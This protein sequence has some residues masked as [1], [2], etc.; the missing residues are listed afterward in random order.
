MDLVIG[1]Y[2]GAGREAGVLP[3]AVRCRDGGQ[4]KCMGRSRLCPRLIW[5][6]CWTGQNHEMKRRS[7]S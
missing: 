3:D 4:R 7:E 1:G 2:D 6:A 5:A